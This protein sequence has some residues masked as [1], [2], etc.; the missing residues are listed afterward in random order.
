MKQ[1]AVLAAVALSLCSCSMHRART[2]RRQAPVTAPRS[3]V[4]AAIERQIIGA[5]YAGEGDY[6]LRSLQARVAAEPDNLPLRLE[7]ARHYQE[8]G[9][10]ELA[11]EHCRLA[12]LRFPDSAEVQIVIAKCYRA[13]G[14]RAEAA[15]GL[16]AYLAKHPQRTPELHSWLGILRDEVGEFQ[17]GEAAHRAALEVAPNQDR[18]HNNLGYNLLQQN[19]RAE[20]AEEFRKALALAPDS[21][22]ARNNLGV[23]LASQP[24]EAL[25]EWQ[26][27]ADQATAHSNLAAALIEQGRHEEARKEVEVALGYNRNHQAAL[28]NLRLLSELDGHPTTVPA[29][30]QRPVWRRWLSAVWKG[31]V[32][33]EE[34]QPQG[35][36]QKAA[37]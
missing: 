28:A 24:A 14:L 33:I 7:L 32:G 25:R 16:E 30:T 3:D 20:A 34:P 21:I 35:V 18:L 15:A 31:L 11:L 2:A 29:R 12:A 6:V 23:A 36:A 22:V 10:H 27:G 19:K 8:L 26:K 37:H 13:M 4:R 1:G 5:R 9:S 17:R